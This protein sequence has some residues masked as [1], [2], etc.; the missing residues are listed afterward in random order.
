M[1]SIILRAATLYLQPIL[2]LFSVFLLLSGH[3][4]PGG[5]FTGGLMAASGF[6]LYALAFS[7]PEARRLLRVDP[8]LL[9]GLGLLVAMGS[10]LASVALGLPL[11]TGL[12]TEIHVPGFG[13]V[14][15]GTPLLFDAGVYLDVVGVATLIIFSMAEE[16]G[17]K[18]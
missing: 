10:A 5:G 18:G 8:Q 14:P 11:M 4:A 6:V 16:D 15:L 13:K 1:N 3:N 12:W 9:I 2:L 7:V 17:R